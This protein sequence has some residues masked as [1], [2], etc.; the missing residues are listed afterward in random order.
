VSVNGGALS[1]ILY[2]QVDWHQKLWDVFQVS[3]RT[4]EDVDLFDME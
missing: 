4:D 1:D 2:T 3:K